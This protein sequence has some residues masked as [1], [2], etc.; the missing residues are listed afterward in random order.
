M[1]QEH[2]Q[3]VC[4]NEV[5]AGTQCRIRERSACPRDLQDRN[6]LR[7]QIKYMRNKGTTAVPTLAAV[8]MNKGLQS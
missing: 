7:T 3:A 1:G 2:G 6:S 8:N 4:R 5:K